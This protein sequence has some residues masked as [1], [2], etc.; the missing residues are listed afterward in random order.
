MAEKVEV[1]GGGQFDGA[2]LQNAASEATL[3]RLVSA[4]EK[5]GSGGTGSGS[6]AQSL[7]DK[8]LKTNAKSIEETTKKHGLYDEVLES[9]RKN[10]KSLAESFK[11]AAASIGSSA[12]SGV[13]FGIEKA[14]EGLISFLNEGLDAYREATSVGASFNGSLIDLSVS[15]MRANMSLDSYGKVIAENSQTL[16]NFGGTV[17]DGAKKFGEL[18][19]DFRDE[20]GDRFFGMG[21]TV[22]DINKSL[23]NYIDIQARA[24]NLQKMDGKALRDGNAQ[25]LDQ[26]E[27]LIRATGMSRKQYEDMS[28]QASIDPVISA[29]RKGLNPEELAKS[30]ANL[31]LAMKIGGKEMEDAMKSMAAGKPNELGK[32][33]MQA[34]F[35]MEDAKK[36]IKG[37][38]DPKE[39]LNRLKTMSATAK[40][41]GTSGNA[42]LNA[43]KAMY[44]SL[45]NVTDGVDAM[46]QADMEKAAASLKDQEKI[47][48]AMGGLSNT[49][50]K[51]KTEI[52]IGLIDSGV[53][54]DLK[55]GLE[56]IAGAFLDNKG[57]I[58]AFFKDFFGAFG[59]DLKTDGLVT[60]LSNAF[61]KLFDTVAP[62]VTNMAG[63]FFRSIVEGLTGGSE[64][65]K[66]LEDKKTKL[67]KSTAQAQAYG[68]VG[69][70]PAELEAVKKEL[71]DMDT[72]NPMSEALDSIYDKVFSLK[73]ILIGGAGLVAAI[74]SVWA[75]FALAPAA[76][77]PFAA[78]VAT[79]ANPFSLV[80]LGALTLAAIGLGAALRLAT[81]AIE[82]LGPVVIK[83]ADVM[84]N[85][86]MKAIEKLPDIIKSAGEAIN[87]LA[88]TISEVLI[89]ALNRIPDVLGKI[90]DI[91]KSV[92]SGAEGILNGFA[93]V[94]DSIFGNIKGTVEALVDGFKAIPMVIGKLS[95]IDPGKLVD[96]GKALGPLSSALLAMGASAGLMAL[97]GPDGLIKLA[98]SLSAF[99]DIDVNKISGVAE[100][101]KSLH[102]ALSLFTG[103]GGGILDSIGSR[104][105]NWLKGDN[106]IGAFAESF[107]KFNEIDAGNM[108]NVVSTL[109]TVKTIVGS[110][111]NNQAKSIDTFAESIRNLNKDIE[112]LNKALS[113]IASEGKGIFGGGKSNLEVITGALGQVSGTAGT[114]PSVA[115]EKLNTQMDQMIVLTTQLRDN[116]K[117]LVDAVRGRGSAMSDRR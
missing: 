113:S 11:N 64:R 42:T 1:R 95:E 98:G 50:E 84:G 100:P 20:T 73:N 52:L 78:G 33:M 87:P 35:S 31:G 79:L 15:A 28:K 13:M 37:G 90:D 106:G 29:L 114:A 102:S 85:V 88:K 72:K 107:K 81:P 89:T 27:G 68:G 112:N 86:F 94:F 2:I 117:D 44:A 105:G 75:V 56:S 55:S 62:I 67:E 80:G 48:T 99:G 34:G 40:D 82:A 41:L 10:T 51:L 103:E 30:T 23:A 38:M 115:T 76:L 26:M 19:K 58:I 8:S 7:Y 39:L 4:L 14:G 21:Y 61:S 109:D 46:S 66:E 116:N 53:F 24:G 22:D 93:R 69:P 36:A 74:G 6:K 60:A 3:M 91:F 45:Q 63:K 25:Y 71:N 65:R 12:L 101:L 54:D 5:S 49:F 9:A 110:D 108:K 111:F 70:N 97:F 32:A 77:G 17:T 18:S 104:I 47:T 16:A 83:I 96:V 43:S 92:F 57:A 59:K